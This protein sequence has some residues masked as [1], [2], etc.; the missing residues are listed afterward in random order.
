MHNEQ[1]QKKITK[2]LKKVGEVKR[3]RDR[4]RER[5]KEKTCN[6][7]IKQKSTWLIWK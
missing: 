4:I 1:Q 7:L 5:E 6:F 3:K 2:N